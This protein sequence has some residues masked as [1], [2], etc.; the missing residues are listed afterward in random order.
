[1]RQV[2]IAFTTTGP[3]PKQG[4][5]I[6]ELVAVEQVGSEQMKRTLHLFFKANDAASD[7]L[8]FA[9]QFDA[10]DQFIAD[11]P[12]ILHDTGAWRKFLRAELQGIKNKGARRLLTQV[13]DVSRW[14]HQRFP[15]H[16]KSVA[17]IAKR[18]NIVVSSELSGLRLTAE[19]LALIG[20]A[21]RS[22]DAKSPQSVATEPV[23]A[24]PAPTPEPGP[25]PEPTPEPAPTVRRARPAGLIE[26]LS[27][28][29]R[30]LVGYDRN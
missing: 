26:K 2:A 8:T 5:R 25:T 19:Q 30:V 10:L 22:A 21:I 23:T 4:H 13:V 17:A 9:T 24:T 7:K 1:M 18:L 20:K 14:A 29:W 28:A 11:A 27:A 15:K 3:S 6:S 16:R 12:I